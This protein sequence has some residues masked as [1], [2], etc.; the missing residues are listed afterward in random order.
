MSLG[1]DVNMMLEMSFKPETLQF[2]VNCAMLSSL[3]QFDVLIVGH[4]L[5]SK[6]AACCN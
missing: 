2:E 5:L 1:K 4:F 6:Y 3:K